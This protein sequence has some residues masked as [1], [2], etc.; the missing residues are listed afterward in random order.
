MDRKLYEDSKEDVVKLHPWGS[1][2]LPGDVA[3]AVA[4]LTSD[5]VAWVT[6]V[7]LPVDGGYMTA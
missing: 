2:G 5:Q 1:L 7:A 3:D 6:G 4:W